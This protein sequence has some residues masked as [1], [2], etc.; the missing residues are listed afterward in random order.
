[1]LCV[2]VCRRA[3]VAGAVNAVRSERRRSS[4]LS[5]EQ[6]EARQEQF[7][8]I[9]S[10]GKGEW[11][12]AGARTGSHAHAHHSQSSFPGDVC[13]SAKQTSAGMETNITIDV[14]VT[15]GIRFG[16]RPGSQPH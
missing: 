16:T 11:V 4:L 5:P 8:R 2:V 10:N 15:A 3:A 9:A 6:L 13:D 7:R 12:R 14:R 1:M